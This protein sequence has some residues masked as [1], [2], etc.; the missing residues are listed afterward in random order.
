LIAESFLGLILEV[1]R[2]RF[3]PCLPAEWKS[4]KV[5]YRHGETQYHITLQN[6]EGNW[7]DRQVVLVDGEEQQD[8][9]VPLR[10]DRRE[11]M[12]EVRFS[13]YGV[14]PAGD[15]SEG[16]AALSAKACV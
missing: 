6:L 15:H 3:A 11:H 12:V 13:E 8:A 1:D 7:K 16:E 5:R 9:S 10:R 14:G 2:L 4:C